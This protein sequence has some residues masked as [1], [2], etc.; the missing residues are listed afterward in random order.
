MR[1]IVS[2]TFV[3]G[4]LKVRINYPRPRTRRSQ[5]PS[6][7]LLG[8]WPPTRIRPIPKRSSGCRSWRSR[9]RAKESKIPAARRCTRRATAAQSTKAAQN[10]S[11]RSLC[12]R[13]RK[14][15]PPNL[16]CGRFNNRNISITSLAETRVSFAGNTVIVQ[17]TAL[18]H[19]EPE[20]DWVAKLQLKHWNVHYY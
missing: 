7:E 9:R 18:E 2:D 15:D 20:L 16:A 3:N 1:G 11:R 10:K 14:R 13:K 12:W 5:W 17:V 8:R 19:T 4:P 6:R